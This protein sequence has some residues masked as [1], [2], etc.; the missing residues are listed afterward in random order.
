MLHSNPLKFNEVESASVSRRNTM[1][2]ERPMTPEKEARLRK[3]ADQLLAEAGDEAVAEKVFNEVKAARRKR[4]DAPIQ[5]PR[6]KYEPQRKG[7]WLAHEEE[8]FTR[9]HDLTDK[10]RSDSAIKHDI[11]RDWPMSNSRY[12]ELIEG[13]SKCTD[14]RNAERKRKFPKRT[15]NS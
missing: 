12:Y 5:R 7:K 9:I 11:F 6:L 10:G 8:I 4:R 15:E 2:H 3:L 1:Q 14:P 13:S